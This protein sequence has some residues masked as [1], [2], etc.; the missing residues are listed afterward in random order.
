MQ[1]SVNEDSDRD[2]AKSDEEDACYDTHEY[3][4]IVEEPADMKNNDDLFYQSFEP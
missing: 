1:D 4:D 2:S 3:N